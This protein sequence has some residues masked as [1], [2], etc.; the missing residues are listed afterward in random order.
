MTNF[1]GYVLAG[2]KSSRM[3]TDKA[4]LEIGGETFL[5]RAVKT[6]SETCENRVKVVLNNHQNN[7]IERLPANI[8]PIF[9]AY[10]N[11]GALGGIHAALTDCPTKY[12]L[13]LA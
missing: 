7:F 9:D 5:S 11:R 13:V 6:L 2:G 8:S 4:F 12:A 1:S 3:Q 10:E